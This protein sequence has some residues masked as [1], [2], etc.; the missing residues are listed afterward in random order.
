MN[1]RQFVR[2][3]RGA[4]K[5][6]ES[7]LKSLSGV[8]LKR[9]KAK[10]ISVYSRLLRELSNDLATIRSRDWGLGLVDYLNALVARGHSAFYAAPPTDWSPLVR[11]LTAEFPRLFRRRIGYFLVAAVLFFVPGG[12]AWA[13][14]QADPSL[15]PRLIAPEQL[16]EFDA[17]YAEQEHDATSAAEGRFRFEEE[18]TA[19]AGFYIQHNVGIALQCFARGILFGVGTV[20]TLLYNGIAIGAV[21]GYVVARGHGQRFLSFVVS[22]GS[23]ELTAI[24]VAGGAGLMLG[25]ALIHPGNRT[26]LEALRVHGLEAVQI[27]GGA[28][29]MLVVAALIEGYWSP[30]PIPAVFKYAAGAVLWTLV[31]L[32]LSLAGRER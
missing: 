15:A 30:A 21:G 9:R 20:C 16:D 10:E 27:A 8:S 5:Q 3:R 31:I 18:R 29:A 24:A 13:V 4:W 6:F 12:L 7:L 25:D 19:M 26:R 2:Q 17:M 11:F 28:A 1:K 22:H 23:F 32:Y 14:I